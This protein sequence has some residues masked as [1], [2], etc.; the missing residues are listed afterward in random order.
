MSLLPPEIAAVAAELAGLGGAFVQKLY[1]PGP[2]TVLLELRRPGR[3]DLV[4]V[5]GEPR[6][7]RVAVVERRPRSPEKPLAF[8]G[9]LRA[10][11]LG[12]RLDRVEADPAR[13]LVL[14]RFS[15]DD[16]E[17]TLVA[18]LDGRGGELLLLGP[19]ETILGAGGP[20]ARARGLVRGA[21]WERPAPAADPPGRARFGAEASDGA[22]PVSAAIEALYGQRS[23]ERR[24]STARAATAAPLRAAVRRAKRTLEKIE[25]DR[26]RIAEAGQWRRLGDLLK[27]H[28][29]A[30]RRGAVEARL[31]E[32]GAEGPVEVTVPLL[33]QLGPRENMERY[34]HLHRRLTRGAAVVEGRA[35]L[36]RRQLEA[37]QRLLAQ[38]ES[39]LDE[40][41]LEVVAGET[42]ALGLTGP[43]AVEAEAAPARRPYREFRSA[44]GRRLWVGRGAR[45]NDALTFAHARGNDLWLHARGQVGAHV[46]VPG[47]GAPGPDG[48]TLVDAATLAAHFSAARQ[49]AVVEVAHTRRKHVHKPK[50]AAPGAVHYSQEKVIA[51]RLEA[52]RLERLLRSEGAAEDAT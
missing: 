50:H 21:A 15:S 39:A 22:F 26:R 43:A 33:P 38:A 23:G 13:R 1:V 29:S 36:V 6:L 16:G 9:L 7:A 3:S 47:V 18:E 37:A 44:S 4:L 14:F 31:T 20:G 25:A 52:G 19:R 24:L 27:P 34:Y 42:R 10:H 12:A 45:D 28:L 30:V 17:R 48:E 46:V 11:L 35:A 51:V 5:E 8:Q 49:E 2:R 32:Y 40:D 41:A